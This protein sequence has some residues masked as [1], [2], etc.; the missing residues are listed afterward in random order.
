MN[1]KTFK[2]IFILIFLMLTINMYGCVSYLPP[3]ELV[4]AES[5][6]SNAQASKAKEYAPAELYE[7]EKSLEKAKE[8]LKNKEKMSKIQF[9]SYLA[10]RKA[11][12]A[13]TVAEKRIAEES[14][15]NAMKRKRKAVLGAKEAKIEKKD[16]EIEGLKEK[17][18]DLRE[19]AALMKGALLNAAGKVIINPSSTN[20]RLALLQDELAQK[21]VYAEIARLEGELRSGIKMEKEMEFRNLRKKILDLEEQIEYLKNKNDGIGTSDQRRSGGRARLTIKDGEKTLIN[22]LV[23]SGIVKDTEGNRCQGALVNLKGTYTGAVSTDSNGA[24]FFSVDEPVSQGILYI[25]ARCGEKTGS[26]KI[27]T[28]SNSIKGDIIVN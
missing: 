17:L 12:I 10:L 20:E 5:A 4:K 1:I 24:Y 26:I 8:S 27:F 11:E 28:T 7:A 13:K 6:F 18:G 25:S 16:I 14:L 9:Y 2:V 3:P 22:N 21:R 19:D 23:I 15:K